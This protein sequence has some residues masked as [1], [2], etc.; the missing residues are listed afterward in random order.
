MSKAHL[1]RIESGTIAV[2][3][4][5]V[6]SLCR[7][8]DAD[9]VRGIRRPGGGRS[10]YSHLRPGTGAWAVADGRLRPGDREGHRSRTEARRGCHRA[11]RI[12]ANG[13]AKGRSEQNT[14]GR[15][16]RSSGRSKPCPASRWP[17]GH[18]RTDGP[19]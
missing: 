11:S 2:N 13:T 8:Y 17:F 4:K 18:V 7:I 14:T 10:R 3:V 15:G 6:W 9:K 16:D 5:D 1:Y 12:T 19:T